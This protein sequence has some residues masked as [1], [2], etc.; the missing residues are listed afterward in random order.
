MVFKYISEN[1]E[2]FYMFFEGNDIEYLNAMPPQILL[3]N[4]VNKH[5]NEGEFA[6]DV[7]YAAICKIF[8]LRI[9]LLTRGYNGLKV[10]NVYFDNENELNNPEDLY[11][12]FINNNHFN[13]LEI[14]LNDTDDTDLIK[15][16]INNSVKNNLLEWE[17]IRKKEYPLSLKWY[18]EIYREMYCFYKYEIIP[19][20]RFNNTKNP[21]VYI[22]RFKNLAMKSFWLKND[23]L[24][25]ECKCKR[26]ENGEFEDLNKVI[27]KKIPFIYE[28]LPKIK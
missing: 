20:E 12:L 6:G 13:Y 11:I 18:P 17:K 2:K 24:Y 15:Q 19:E 21:G 25:Y 5:N 26:L 4:Y 8:N 3:Q 28:I 1:P 16:T 9:V 22:K 7:E 23:L 10:F 14:N 27:L